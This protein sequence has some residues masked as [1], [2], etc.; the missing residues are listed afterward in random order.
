MTETTPTPVVPI[1]RDDR[2]TKQ[3]SLYEASV[4]EIFWRNFLAGFSRTL[5]AV[6]IYFVF[7]GIVSA[8]F[9]AIAWPQIQPMIGMYSK[10]IDSLNSLQEASKN[11]QQ[12]Q[13]GIQD[14]LQRI[15]APK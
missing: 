14:M 10:S 1:D 9:W 6:F 8:I 11:A 12:G 7:M 13:Q 3:K 5:G 4:G 15:Q 2:L